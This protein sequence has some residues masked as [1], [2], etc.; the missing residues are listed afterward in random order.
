[1]KDKIWLVIAFAAVVGFVT[2]IR[3]NDNMGR[4]RGNSWFTVA[5][6]YYIQQ[7]L[8]TDDRIHSVRTL[9]QN[10]KYEPW[11]VLFLLDDPLDYIKE[12]DQ[13]LWDSTEDDP[14][15]REDVRK[16]HDQ[17]ESFRVARIAKA[18][19]SIQRPS[20]P[21]LFSITHYLNDTR[22]GE[23]SETVSE[24]LGLVRIHKDFMLTRPLNEVARE[25][26]VQLLGVDHGYDIVKWRDE[27]VHFHFPSK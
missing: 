26:L 21:L 6:P 17:I 24:Y 23:Y 27:I 13:L 3:F 11:A 4:S 5:D 15:L 10:P 20:L 2:G 25:T 8:T 7:T 18:I 19:E 9:I 14:E 16:R 22:Q 1:M 12:K